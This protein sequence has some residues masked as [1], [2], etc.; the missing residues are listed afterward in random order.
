MR[1]FEHCNTAR[2]RPNSIVSAVRVKNRG[3]AGEKN[4]FSL[5]RAGESSYNAPTQ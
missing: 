1:I 4:R 2:K 3:F 5:A